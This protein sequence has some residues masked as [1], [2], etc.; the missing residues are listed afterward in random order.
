M[1]STVV[2]SLKPSKTRDLVM[3]GASIFFIFLTSPLS[4][5]SATSYQYVIEILSPVVGLL[6][7]MLMLSS[8]VR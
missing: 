7:D 4:V 2:V 6:E 3:G 1:S 5:I 8:A